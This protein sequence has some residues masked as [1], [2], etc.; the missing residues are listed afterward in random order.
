MTSLAK[1]HTKKLT[2]A[3]IQALYPYVNTGREWHVDENSF[4]LVDKIVKLW[5][6]TQGYDFYDNPYPDVVEV[7]ITKEKEIEFTYIENQTK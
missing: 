4:E 2:T 1:R 5:F 6:E 3:E 7:V